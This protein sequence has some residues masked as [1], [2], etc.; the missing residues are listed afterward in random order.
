[1]QTSN[2]QD[3]RDTS[4]V[5][6]AN[7]DLAAKIE[8]WKE[9]EIRSSDKEYHQYVKNGQSEYRMRMKKQ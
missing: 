1:V 9:I 2:E 7:N 3:I 5:P 8:G 6:L 4:E